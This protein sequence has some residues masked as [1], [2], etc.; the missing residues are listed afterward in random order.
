[1]STD[2]DLEIRAEASIILRR[3]D[4]CRFR[5]DEF[6]RSIDGPETCDPYRNHLWFYVNEADR[7]VY[8]K[9]LRIRRRA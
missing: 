3:S 8:R 9:N 7:S 4:W 2:D 1:M 6:Y 5:E